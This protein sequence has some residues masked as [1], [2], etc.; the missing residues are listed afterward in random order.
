MQAKL[1]IILPSAADSSLV[2]GHLNHFTVEFR[3][4]CLSAALNEFQSV[5]MSKGF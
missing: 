3:N 1:T 4:W 5:T 2:E